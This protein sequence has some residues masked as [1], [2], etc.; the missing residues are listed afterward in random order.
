MQSEIIIVGFTAIV[1]TQVVS[2][3]AGQPRSRRN[4]GLIIVLSSLLKETNGYYGRD[5]KESSQ[6]F[7]RVY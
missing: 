2:A 6:K 3:L 7:I 5:S 4:K 1:G